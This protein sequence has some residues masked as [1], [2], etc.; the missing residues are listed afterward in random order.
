M[1]AW[2][3]ASSTDHDALATTRTT[4]HGAIQDDIVLVFFQRLRR[5]EVCQV[6]VAV[7][8]ANDFNA[9]S[10]E[11]SRCGR[12]NCVGRWSWAASEQDCNSFKVRLCDVG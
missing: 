12:D 7:L 6:A 9:R 8:D 10:Y 11:R 2:I 5:I 3:G 1:F 4:Q